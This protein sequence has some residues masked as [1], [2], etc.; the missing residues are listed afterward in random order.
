VTQQEVKTKPKDSNAPPVPAVPKSS[1][2]Q[3]RLELA[4]QQL[5]QKQ[6]LAVIKFCNDFDCELFLKLI[7]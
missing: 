5:R 4:R 7:V 1:E 6:G 2:I 3:K